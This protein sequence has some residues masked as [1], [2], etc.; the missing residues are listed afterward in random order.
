MIIDKGDK[1]KV[2]FISESATEFS[3]KRFQGVGIVD[4]VED[5]YVFGRLECGSPF[6]CPIADV[7][8]VASASSRSDYENWFEKQSFY[9]QMLFIHGGKLFDFDEGIGYRTLPVQIG[10]VAYLREDKEFVL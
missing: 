4:R 5:S 9:H 2:D 7:E 1:V 8:L 3:G 10:Y 6:L